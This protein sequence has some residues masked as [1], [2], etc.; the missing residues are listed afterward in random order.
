MFAHG[1]IQTTATHSFIY[2][3][4]DEDFGVNNRSSVQTQFAEGLA[5]EDVN[6]DGFL[7][8]I[9]TS[10]MCTGCQG[11]YIYFGEA[12]GEYSASNRL[13]INGAIGSTD[14]RVADLDRDGQKDIVFANGGIA[15]TGIADKSYVYFQSN[16]DFPKEGRIE[17]PT[18]VCAAT[19]IGDLDGD[20]FI[21]I[22]FASHYAPEA[23]SLEVSQIYWGAAG[24]DYGPHSLTELRTTHA[25]GVKIVGTIF[26]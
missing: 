16:G 26:K 25:A 2:W 5:I 4:G 8:I 22:V 12:S 1:V 11:N 13:T 19:D 21:D 24:G 6:D 3:G 9:F 23:S 10:W 14:A 18:S 15:P 20:G 17:L 7:D